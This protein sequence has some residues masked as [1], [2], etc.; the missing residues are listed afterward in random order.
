MPSNLTQLVLGISGGIASGKSAAAQV[1]A[2]ESGHIIAADAIAHQVLASPEVSDLVATNFGPGALGPDGTPD[3]AAL[4]ELVF[5]IP[6]NRKLLESWIHPAV[7]ARIFADLKSA[8]AK[9]TPVVV[10]DV[11]LLFENDA[12]HNLVA[13]CD[14]LVFVDAPA[15]QRDARAVA[16][17]GWAAG[18]VARREALQLPLETKRSAS[19]HV[20]Q[21]DGDIDH[22]RREAKRVLDAIRTSK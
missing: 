16:N 13:A 18:E 6:S 19:H 8:A 15:D 5:S 7:R 11:P 17:R 2:G 1:L 12:D 21:N 20:I 10:L 14:Y 9:A 3:R 4:G 22:L